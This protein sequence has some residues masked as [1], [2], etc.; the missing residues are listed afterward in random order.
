MP[1]TAERQCLALAKLFGGASLGLTI[2]ARVLA[3]A[4]E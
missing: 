1:R 2:P 3:I 4:D